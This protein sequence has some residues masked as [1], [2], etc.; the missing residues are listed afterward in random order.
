M[1]SLIEDAAN[2]GATETS[3]PLVSVKSSL[4]KW[5]GRHHHLVNRYVISVSQWPLICSTYRKH[6]PSLSH[7]RV[8]ILF[9]T[10]LTRRMP[11]VQQDLQTLLERPSSPR[12]LVGLVLLDLWLYMYVLQIVVF[13]FVLFVFAIVLSVLWYTDFDCPFSIFHLF[14]VK[15]FNY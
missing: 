9:V 7:S 4:R 8:I 5:Y 6:F 10:R 14:L 12:S 2:T 11:L 3:V 1:I 13:P 15:S